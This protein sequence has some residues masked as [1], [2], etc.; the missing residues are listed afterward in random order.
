[1]LNLPRVFKITLLFSILSVSLAQA[2]PYSYGVITDPDGWTNVRREPAPTAPVIEKVNDSDR[3]IIMNTKG[4][5]YDCLLLFVRDDLPDLFGY[6]HKSRVKNVRRA[7]GAGI[8]NDPD[9]WSYLRSQPSSKSSVVS[10]LWP[11]DGF[12]VILEKSSDPNWYRVESRVGKVGFLHKSRIE[13]V[14]P[15]N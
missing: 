6:I 8:I 2:S 14:I 4:A 3:V 9:G 15:R 12:F 7:L 5:Y 11:E 1:M 13:W 10:K